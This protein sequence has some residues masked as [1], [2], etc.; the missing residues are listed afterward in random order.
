MLFSSKAKAHQDKDH[1][2]GHDSGHGRHDGLSQA[3]VDRAY[4][5][6]RRDERAHH[7]GHP[8]LALVVFLVAVM[9]AGMVILAASE[10]SFTRG[11]QVLDHKLSGV[12]DHAWA[13]SRRA[14]VLVAD[15]GRVIKQNSDQN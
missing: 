11:G 6:G 15:A 7:R 4:Q 14:N 12:A 13:G 2:S 3:D 1:D 5:R 8:L 9:G 10:G